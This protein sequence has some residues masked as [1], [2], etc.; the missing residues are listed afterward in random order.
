MR[1]GGATCF[2]GNKILHAQSTNILSYKNK[3]A[4]PQLCRAINLI[5]LQT[6]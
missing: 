2:E 1:E 6:I 5:G 3:K 4:L